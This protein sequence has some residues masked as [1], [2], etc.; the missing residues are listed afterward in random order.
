MIETVVMI[1]MKRKEKNLIFAS[2]Q[3]T[4]EDYRTVFLAIIAFAIIGIAN[5]NWFVAKCLF[6]CAGV[7]GSSTFGGH[8]ILYE[9]PLYSAY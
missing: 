8:I 2:V 1:R 4:I 3:A 5:D 7:P 6:N 9:T